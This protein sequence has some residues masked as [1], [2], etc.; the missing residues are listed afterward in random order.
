MT[1]NLEIKGKL[2]YGKKL[3][4]NGDKWMIMGDGESL[5]ECNED[6]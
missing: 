6:F 4:R 1:F 3:G 2:E 5:K